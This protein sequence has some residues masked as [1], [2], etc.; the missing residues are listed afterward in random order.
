MRLIED[1]LAMYPQLPFILIGDSG[2]RDPEVYAEVV[3]RHPGRIRTI[4]IR[5]MHQRAGRD[6]AIQNLAERVA[7][8]GCEM[9]LARDSLEMAEHALRHGWID[10]KGMREVQTDCRRRP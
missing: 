10:E 2:Q 9:I 8:Q 5:H 4:Y 7:G 6:R 1:M 3:A